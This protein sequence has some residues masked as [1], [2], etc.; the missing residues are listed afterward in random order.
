MTT[1]NWI[2]LAVS[3]T[4]ALIALRLLIEVGWLE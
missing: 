4:I 2:D 1:A 3:A